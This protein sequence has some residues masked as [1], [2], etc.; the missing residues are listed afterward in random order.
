M[1]Q[2]R[3]FW[4]VVLIIVGVIFALN[5]LKIIDSSMVWNIL[6]PVLII[7]FGLWVLVRPLLRG[8]NSVE[9]IDLPSGDAAEADMRID[10]GAGRLNISAGTDEGV[11][12]HGA[13]EGGV[14][15]RSQQVN[16]KIETHLR[17][18]A[19]AF[20]PVGWGDQVKWDIF[21][22]SQLPLRL[23]V[24]SGA[25]ENNLDF[26]KLHLRNLKIQSGASSTR[27]VLPENGT[28]TSVE[29]N[30]GAASISFQVPEGVAARIQTTGALSSVNINTNRFPRNGN[31]YESVDYSTA[32]NKI[33][34][35][36]EI[37]VGSV[38][39]G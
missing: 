12:L 22:N 21:L 14:D 13:C 11:F 23:E 5:N 20:P 9:N 30:G 36:I 8:K 26:R 2:N 6:A 17:L 10:F 19:T 18:P 1:N 27:V 33:D 4:G 35:D 38:V 34:L 3:L 7:T 37:G 25:S 31:R 32:E 28:Y 29:A 39:V 24:Q 15:V 16:Q